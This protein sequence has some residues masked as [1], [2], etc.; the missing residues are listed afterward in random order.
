MTVQN[1]DV[2]RINRKTKR[3]GKLPEKFEHKFR[4]LSRPQS[5]GMNGV[6]ADELSV[7]FLAMAH[8]PSLYWL[9]P[10]RLF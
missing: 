3:C 10:L 4:A 9:I 6:L 2:T 8:G 1:S 5:F 7:D